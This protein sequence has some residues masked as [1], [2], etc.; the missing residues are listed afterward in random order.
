MIKNIETISM[1]LA[2]SGGLM[3]INIILGTLNGTMTE[4]FDFKK[5]FFGIIKALVNALCIVGTCC[6]CDIFAQVINTIDG[7][8]ISTQV[9]STLEIIAVVVAWCLDLFKDVFE[10]IKALKDMK[11]VS[12]DNVKPLGVG[13]DE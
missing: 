11:Y 10:K 8:T 4:R 9:I 5:F 6:L 1:L 3:I 2:I 7:I 12:Y 13:Q